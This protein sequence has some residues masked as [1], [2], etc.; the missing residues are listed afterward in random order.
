MPA[1]APKLSYTA[2]L[3]WIG[4]S[5]GDFHDDGGK[6]WRSVKGG[7]NPAL[8]NAVMAAFVPVI[9]KDGKLVPANAD[10]KE[11]DEH[12]NDIT[13][14]KVGWIH[15]CEID[16]TRM[17]SIEAPAEAWQWRVRGVLVVL[18]YNEAKPPDQT[19]PESYSGQFEMLERIKPVHPAGP[20]PI[21]ALPA[22][23]KE[24]TQ[25]RLEELLKDE[26]AAQLNR[27]VVR[28]PA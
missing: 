1:P 20:T 19:H 14:A 16:D 21:S 27:A 8:G 4:P 2:E 9:L 13:V 12:G 11:K 5:A 22:A 24:E 10:G 28:P 6:Y 25:A 26:T 18:L 15:A 17:F 7:T 3:P 23:M